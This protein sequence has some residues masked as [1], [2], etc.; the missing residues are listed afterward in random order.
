VE[1]ALQ[2]KVHNSPE[3]TTTRQAT[4]AGQDSIDD[5]ESQNLSARQ[6][7]RP[8]TGTTNQQFRQSFKRNPG[9]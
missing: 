1:P 5:E 7:K 2:I 4:P 8:N 9:N 6:K 3:D